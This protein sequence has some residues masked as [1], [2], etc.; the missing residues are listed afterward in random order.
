MG[1]Q[2]YRQRFL[3]LEGLLH[4]QRM[5]DADATA[6]AVLKA[7]SALAVHAEIL[8]DVVHHGGM[9]LLSRCLGS[10]TKGLQEQTT[11]CLATLCQRAN[12]ETLG[13]ARSAMQAYRGWDILRTMPDSPSGWVR[14]NA[15]AAARMA[16]D[17]A[18][19]NVN[20]TPR[21]FFRVAF[22]GSAIYHRQSSHL[23]SSVQ[24]T[25]QDFWECLEGSSRH[26]WY[27]TLQIQGFLS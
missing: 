13:A 25:S 27:Q 21:D 6:G 7:L 12:K 5:L 24:C 1:S 17:T 16:L 10:E 11:E 3:E 22:F 19:G 15:A 8:H 20:E 26:F 2:A 4:L 14:D 18:E 23:S 9:R